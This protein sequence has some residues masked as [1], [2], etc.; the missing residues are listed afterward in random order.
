[1]DRIRLALA[2]AGLEL[3]LGCGEERV[4][5]AALSDPSEAGA[6]VADAP[7]AV[8]TEAVAREILAE[9]LDPPGAPGRRLTLIRYTIAPGADLPPHIHPGVQMASIESGNLSYGVVSGRAVI[10]R[11]VGD[12]GVPASTEEL[13]GPGETTLG[14]GDAVVEMAEMV[15]YGGNETLQP[16][17][18]VASLITDPEQALA[19]EA[20]GGRQ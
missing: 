1:M 12:D 18:I 20:T 16:I 7:E 5:P 17:V 6:A 8:S 3:L 13:V 15:H 2:M 10:H 19:I 11:S 14:P 4:E 9:V